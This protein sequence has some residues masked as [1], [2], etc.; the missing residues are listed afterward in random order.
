MYNLPPEPP[1]A[2]LK[3]MTDYPE[4]TDLTRILHMRTDARTSIIIP[5]SHYSQSIRRALRKFAQINYF[6]CLFTGHELYGDIKIL[7]YHLIDLC[8]DFSNLRGRRLCIENIITLRFLLFHMG[9]ART[10]SPEHPHH[11][12]IQQVLR[13]MC[14]LIFRLVMGIEYWTFHIFFQDIIS[15]TLFYLP[16]SQ[17]YPDSG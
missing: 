17:T 13:R 5:Y 4:C 10:L 7:R 11:C 14:R 16:P 3:R 15:I 12:G 9:I 8:L 1:H 6:C 2:I